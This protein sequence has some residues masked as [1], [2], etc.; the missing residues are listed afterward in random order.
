MTIRQLRQCLTEIDNQE[1]TVRKLRELLFNQ[2]DQEEEVSTA[3]N[4]LYWVT[5]G[6]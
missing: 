5:V 2:E 1:M 3:A 6:E 4:T